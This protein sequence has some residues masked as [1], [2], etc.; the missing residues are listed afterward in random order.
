[1]K[2]PSKRKKSPSEME[3]ELLEAAK[4]KVV[5][6]RLWG[7]KVAS[8]AP[9]KQ[10]EQKSFKFI[11]ENLAEDHEKAIALPPAKPTK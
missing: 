10:S 5:K 2:K 9:S 11:S 8:V 6:V 4:G 7:K 3:R 1:M